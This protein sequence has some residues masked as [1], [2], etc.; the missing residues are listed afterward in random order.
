MPLSGTLPLTAGK[1]SFPSDVQR[2]LFC[3]RKCD[4]LCAYHQ[5]TRKEQVSAMLVQVRSS[6]GLFTMPLETRLLSDRKVFIRGAINEDAAAAFFQQVMLLSA[7]D[8][9]RLYR[10]PRR[11]FYRRYVYTRCGTVLPYSPARIL[12]R[13]SVQHG[14]CDIQRISK[15]QSIYVSSYTPPDP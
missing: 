11:R 14:C 1:S 4:L 5:M 13:A 7:E 3:I 2:E 8:G 6:G 10:L 15:G 12:H 9:H